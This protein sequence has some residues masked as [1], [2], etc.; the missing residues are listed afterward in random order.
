MQADAAEHEER[1]RR[2]AQSAQAEDQRH[3][4]DRKGKEGDDAAMHVDFLRSMKKDAYLNTS[5]TVEARLAKQ[6]H[7]RQKGPLDDQRL[8]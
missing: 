1:R 3:A 2:V 6:K 5:D 4:E 8:I 7:F